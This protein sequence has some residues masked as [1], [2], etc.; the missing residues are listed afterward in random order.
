MSERGDKGMTCGEC[1]QNVSKDSPFV[2]AVGAIDDFQAR[3]G[4]ARVLLEENE[5]E[6]IL[7]IE[8][9]LGE[10]MGI[11]FSGTD[12]TR[13]K[14]RVEEI[15]DGI[16]NYRGRVENL[17]KFLIPGENEIESRLNLCR[18]GCRTAERRII[19]L[20]EDREEKEGLGLDEN[21]LK[22]FNKLSTYLYW[23]WRSKIK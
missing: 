1:L 17:D 14:K 4:S 8:K 6:N 9:D 16:K 2:E 15:E 11:L 21:I 10:V 18:T 22:Y 3:L 12:W 5:N 13:G 20:K 7:E 23:M 19:T